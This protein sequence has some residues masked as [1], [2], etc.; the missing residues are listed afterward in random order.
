MCLMIDFLGYMVVVMY[1]LSLLPVY[2]ELK[3][4]LRR[5]I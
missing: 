2:F 5:L 1:S 3:A 4:L